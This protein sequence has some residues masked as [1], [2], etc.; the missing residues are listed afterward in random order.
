MHWLSFFIGAL[1]GWLI[2][3]LIDWLVCRPRRRAAEVPVEGKPDSGGGSTGCRH[4]DCKNCVCS[5]TRLIRRGI[6]VEHYL[7]DLLLAGAVPTHNCRRNLFVYVADR[8][9]DPYP[10][11]PVPAIPQYNCFV[12]ASGGARGHDCPAEPF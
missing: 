9:R 7:V 11:I 8:P 1:V 12:G 3:W 2:G 5:Q 10:D 6:E 4:R